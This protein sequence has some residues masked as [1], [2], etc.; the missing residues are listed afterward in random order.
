MKS[1]LV[2]FLMIFCVS[3]SSNTDESVDIDDATILEYIRKHNLTAQKTSSGLYYVIDKPGTGAN[4]TSNSTVTVNYKLYLTNGNLVEEGKNYTTNLQNVIKGWTE[5]FTYFNKDAE[6]WLLIPS[7]L[8]YGS[9]GT[10]GIPGGTVL[11]FGVHL[12]DFN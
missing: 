4:A 9:Q 2:L 3:C 11:V 5:G 10:T 1:Y 7:R 12:L 8:G 6:G